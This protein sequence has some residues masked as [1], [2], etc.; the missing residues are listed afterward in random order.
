MKKLIV[1][2][3]LISAL[4]I[5]HYYR[6]VY[7]TISDCYYGD[8]RTKYFTEHPIRCILWMEFDIGENKSE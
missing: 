5:Y 3:L 1:F 6:A 7:Y 2:W 8:V 4:P